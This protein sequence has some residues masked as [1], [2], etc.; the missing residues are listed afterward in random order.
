M[1]RKTHFVYNTSDEKPFRSRLG[2]RAVRTDVNIPA[3]VWKMAESLSES[4]KVHGQKASVTEEQEQELRVI[5]ENTES[6]GESGSLW[7]YTK[8]LGSSSYNGGFLR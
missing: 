6:S 3:V 4:S 5:E 8:K 2:S 7:Y 1:E